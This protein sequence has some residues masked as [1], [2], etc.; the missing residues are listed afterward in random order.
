[1]SRKGWAIIF[2]CIFIILSI[3][4]MVINTKLFAP[5]KI[6]YHA[7]FVVFENDKRQDFSDVKYMHIK[8]CTVKGKDNTE[9][10]SDE[11]NQIE[12]AH[13]HDYVGDVVHVHREDVIWKDLFT[14]LKYNIDYAKATAYINGKE[15]KNFQDQ[16]IQPY[17]SL[18]V[19]IGKNNIKEHLS[20]GV[21]KS[22]IQS[23]EKKSEEC[24]S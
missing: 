12:K 9:S 21:N 3:L 19:F 16:E 22:H 4:G 15:V 10:E 1:M 13:L 14:N 2:I 7:G 17:D 20:E 18:I 6:H 8:P 11:D 24:G 23:V 5:K